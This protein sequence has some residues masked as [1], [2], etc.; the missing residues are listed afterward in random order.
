MF[1]DRDESKKII[2][3]FARPQHKNHEWVADEAPEY[4]AFITPTH[5]EIA[6]QE[7]E[8]LIQAK[9]REMA[10]AELIAEGKLPEK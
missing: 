6:A 9:I 10:E 1:V 2:R 8:A 5:E 7:T 4:I 3:S